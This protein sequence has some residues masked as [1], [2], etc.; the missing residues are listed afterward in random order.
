[1]MNALDE[2]KKENSRPCN[3]LHIRESGVCMNRHP[4]LAKIVCI[5]LHSLSLVTSKVLRCNQNFLERDEIMIINF[6][7]EGHEDIVSKDLVHNS[8]SSSKN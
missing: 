1:M 2:E 3:N 7:S 8:K 5:N 4:C 6:D